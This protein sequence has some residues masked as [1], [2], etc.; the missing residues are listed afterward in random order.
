MNLNDYFS[1]GKE[2]IQGSNIPEVKI[3]TSIGRCYNYVFLF[4]RE[5]CKGHPDSQ[6][7]S[8][9]KGDHQAAIRFLTSIEERRLASSL[10]DLTDKRNIAEY[11]LSK[12]YILTHASDYINDAE[13]F[14]RR[15]SQEIQNIKS[16]RVKQKY[17]K[18][19]MSYVKRI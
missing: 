19:S 12:K 4:V 13:D 8:R 15:F 2:L 17:K 9:G 7:S 14:V 3:R 10:I 11:D 16:K 6:F 5:N 18:R 1:L